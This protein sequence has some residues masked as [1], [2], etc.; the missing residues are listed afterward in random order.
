M[1][2]G[3]PPA[4]TRAA[5]QLPVELLLQCL[6][7]AD[8]P[9]RICAS[10]VSSIWREAALA[11]RRL[12]DT[13]S[14]AEFRDEQHEERMFAQLQVMLLRSHPLPFQLEIPYEY[15]GT[16]LYCVGRFQ[17][18]ESFDLQRLA[19]YRGPLRIFRWLKPTQKQ[20]PALVYLFAREH[21]LRGVLS[22][23]RASYMHPIELRLNSH[24]D[25][26][27]LAAKRD[28]KT[29]LED[30]TEAVWK[31]DPHPSVAANFLASIQNPSC[32]RLTSISVP[33]ARLGVLFSARLHAPRLNKIVFRIDSTG[34][35][36]DSD[37]LVLPGGAE[38]FL[39]APYLRSVFFAFDDDNAD[40][41]SSC[42]EGAVDVLSTLR[43]RFRDV[44]LYDATLLDAVFVS[45]AAE[46]A[47]A[48]FSQFAKAYKLV[49]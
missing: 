4:E 3:G 17:S 49:H 48:E 12:W 16:D 37:S 5:W 1:S 18:L 27:T 29:S 39:R 21:S 28:D 46:R 24:D 6:L 45:H 26:V 20:L 7:A 36:D 44:L 15:D 13:F 22:L 43:T 31:I 32:D 19:T 25:S 40:P 35:H 9:T 34:H 42:L 38:F 41:P 2:P 47:C 8:M 23:F 33:L 10:Q 11:E 14:S 30:N